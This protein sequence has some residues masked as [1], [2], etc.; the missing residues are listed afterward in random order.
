MKA[1]AVLTKTMALLAPYLKRSDITEIVVNRPGEVGL[2]RDDGTW[3]FIKDK[4]F[5][6][7]NIEH[8]GAALAAD[9]NQL[10]NTKTPIYAGR[11]P[12]YG[13]RIQLCM[14]NMV[15]SGVAMAIR[16][17]KGKDYPMEAFMSEPEAK[18][19]QR[20][21]RDGKTILICAGTGTGKTTLMNAMIQ[22]IPMEERIITLEDTRELKIPH[23]NTVNFTNSKTGTDLAGLEFKDFINSMMR[24]NPSRILLGE[25]DTQNTLAFLN[26][27]NSGHSGSISTIHASS[28]AEAINRMSGNA[29]MAGARADKR[30]IEA[31]ACEAIDVFV[32]ITKTF[33][34]GKKVFNAEFT[35]AK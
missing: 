31:Y 3:E 27:A 30:D 5:T 32:M 28:P 10:F 4:A 29:Q 34:D 17:S 25:I 26:L 13:H 6:L 18:A 7:T 1:N 9:A 35:L 11:L 19:L 12:Q 33:Q 20:M 21:I 15:E 16:V 8:L 23:H 22:H 2:E 14:G 24:M